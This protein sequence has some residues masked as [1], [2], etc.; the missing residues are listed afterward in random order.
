MSSR[1]GSDQVWTGKC[2]RLRA[3]VRLGG[4]RGGG[5]GGVWAEASGGHTGGEGWMC[6]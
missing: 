5:G 6:V 2:C 3:A 1:P 4:A